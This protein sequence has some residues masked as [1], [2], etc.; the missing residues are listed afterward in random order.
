MTVM[1]K[2]IDCGFLVDH[3]FG[4]CSGWVLRLLALLARVVRAGAGLVVLREVVRRAVDL[5]EAALR[6]VDLLAVAVRGGMPKTVL[7]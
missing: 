1:V 2:M 6:E 5:R 3:G 7:A 4:L